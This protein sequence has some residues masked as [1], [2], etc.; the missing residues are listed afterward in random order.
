MLPTE[1]WREKQG[2]RRGP[3]FFFHLPLILLE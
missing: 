3:A 1:N 2:L